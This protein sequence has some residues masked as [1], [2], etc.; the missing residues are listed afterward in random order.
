MTRPEGLR[1]WNSPSLRTHFASRWHFGDPCE[2]LRPVV[3]AGPNGPSP[4]RW[5]RARPSPSGDSRPPRDRGLQ[6]RGR[7][8][9]LR[10]A[11]ATQL[12]AAF[13]TDVQQL[14]VGTSM[15]ATHG[16]SGRP[17]WSR[18]WTPRRRIRDHP[19][20]DAASGESPWPRCV[21]KVPAD[22]KPGDY[23]G[24]RVSCEDE[25]PWK[26]PCGWRWPT[27]RTAHPEKSRTLGRA[28]SSS[29]HPATRI[30]RARL[31]G[32]ALQTD[33][34]LFASV[35]SGVVYVRAVAPTTAT[36]R[37]CPVGQEEARRST[38][39]TSSVMDR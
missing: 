32:Q 36:K 31:V 12:P 1:G 20:P 18:C 25:K 23:D 14:M 21:I 15:H 34:A 27:G 22:A 3:I 5:R 37:P 10:G 38:T 8:I 24:P 30:R 9:L 4:R 33:C 17:P 28:R 7:T 19:R 11:I 35:G 39:S 29:R 13:S 16:N 6:G 26:C 2:T